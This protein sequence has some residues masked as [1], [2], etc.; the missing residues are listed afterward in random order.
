M[1]A[2]AKRLRLREGVTLD[3]ARDVLWLVTSPELYD[4]MVIRR[5]WSPERFGR[6]V[7]DTISGAL[8]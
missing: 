8:F 5:R 3:E 6:F 7:T 4:L 1:T 2:N